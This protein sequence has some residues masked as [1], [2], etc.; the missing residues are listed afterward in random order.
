MFGT[1]R[2]SLAL[3]LVASAGLAWAQDPNTPAPTKAAF[4]NESRDIAASGVVTPTAEMWFYQQE[5][6]RR[7]DPKMAIRRR[8]EMRAMQRENRIAA[9]AWYGMSKSRPMVSPTPFV[10][11]Y[12]QHWTSNTYDP[13]R[14]Q[15]GA[16][17]IIVARPQNRPY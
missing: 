6:S 17:T 3:F 15:P 8:A 4:G 16:P 13:F 14:W 7:D 11:G 1:F 10:S 9:Q 2:I 5:Q 12:S